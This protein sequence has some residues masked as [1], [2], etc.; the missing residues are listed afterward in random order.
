MAKNHLRLVVGCGLIVALLLGAHA[1]WLYWNDRPPMWDSALHLTYAL[2]YLDYFRSGDFSLEGVL[3]LTPYYPP[4][5]YLALLPV[6]ALRAGPDAATLLHWPFLALLVGAVAWIGQRCFGDRRAALL[7]AFL[8][9]TYP[10]VLWLCRDV[11][12]DLEVVALTAAIVALGLTTRGFAS[13]GWTLALGGLS[14][15]ALLVKWTVAFYVGAPLAVLAVAAWRSAPDRSE[16]RRAAG[17]LLAAALLA[18]LIAWPWYLKN[19]A[20]LVSHFL[21]YTQGLGSLEGDPGLWTLAGWTFYL[22]ALCSWQLFG[23]FFLLFLVAVAAL[24]RRHLA[25]QEAPPGTGPV[26]P[27]GKNTLALVLLL[28]WVAGPYLVFSLFANKA[29]RHITPVLPAV[30]LLTAW[31]VVEV[32]AAWVRRGLAA[33]VVLTALLQAWMVSFGLPALPERLKVVSL[34]APAFQQRSVRFEGG[35]L[36]GE[37]FFNWPDGWFLYQQDAFGLWGAPRRE[38]WRIP[39]IIARTLAAPGPSA[40]RTSLGLVPDAARF[41]V[42]SF[43]ATACLMRRELAVWRIGSFDVAGTAFDPYRFVLVKD[44]DQGPAWGS[45]DNGRLTE[46]VFTHPDRFAEAGRWPLPDG[47]TAWLFENRRWR[48]PAEPGWPPDF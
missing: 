37:T 3:S 13:R 21:P 34:T 42:W 2:R 19:I 20:F 41:N 6:L 11:L 28:A 48:W 17:N 44:G 24:V 12:I 18:G 4:L 1:A 46:Y 9:G 8:A 16:R 45:A 5:Y 36:A 33:A 39:K 22:R 43:R 26:A 14:G 30:A 23:P 27:G 29:P 31:F 7:A 47:S 32:K 10:H 40:E 25:R 15:A 35:R 38:N